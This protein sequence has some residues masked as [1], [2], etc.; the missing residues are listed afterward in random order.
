MNSV[1]FA[2][3][4]MYNYSSM[5]HETSILAPSVQVSTGQHDGLDMQCSAGV[6]ADDACIFYH[7]VHHSHASVRYASSLRL[8]V[9]S[10]HDA[11]H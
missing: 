3:L 8:S 10:D 11:Q 1:I 9:G 5:F 6:S 2:Q 7:I 4:H